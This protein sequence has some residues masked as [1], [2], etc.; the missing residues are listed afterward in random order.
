MPYAEDH[1]ML[2][3]EYALGTLDA[4]EREQAEAMMAMDGEFEAIVTAWQL[5][6]AALNQMVGPVEPRGLVWE[7]IQAAIASEPGQRALEAEQP[8]GLVIAAPQPITE[9]TTAERTRTAGPA[10]AI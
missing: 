8:A 2:A 6:L 5:R 1:I 10:E 3:A 9:P 4:E 7:R